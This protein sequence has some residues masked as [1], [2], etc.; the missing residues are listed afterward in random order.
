LK[1][2]LRRIARILTFRVTAGDLERLGLADLAVGL[3]MTWLVGMGRHWDNPRASPLQHLGVGSVVYVFVLALYLYLVVAPMRPERWGYRRLLTYVALTSPPAALYALPVERW[4]SL[5][6]AAV[7]NVWFLAVV[8]AW[9]VAMYAV[10]LRRWAGLR[11]YAQFCA[12]VLPLV[13]LVAALAALNLDHVVFRI[14]AG[15]RDDHTANDL[16][17]LVLLAL[18]WFSI[19]FSPVLLVMYVVAVVTRRRKESTP[20]DV[21][22]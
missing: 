22:S 16:A 8:A 11:G 13:L 9:R 17:Y 15:L 7:A 5:T 12:A 10:Y 3:V 2:Y 1:E 4:L 19:F 21:G 20:S 18:T 14:M 6:S